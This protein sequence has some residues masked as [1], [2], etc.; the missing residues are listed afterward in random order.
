LCTVDWSAKVIRKTGANRQCQNRKRKIKLREA[1]F[2]VLWNENFR[3]K[4]QI[5]CAA[6]WMKRELWARMMCFC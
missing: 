6:N 5:K 4:V 1:S 3:W 2:F